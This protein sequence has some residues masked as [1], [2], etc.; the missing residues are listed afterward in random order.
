M[1][2]ALCDVPSGMP[3]V[4]NVVSY[5]FADMEKAAARN[6]EVQAARVRKEKVLGKTHMKAV[7]KNMNITV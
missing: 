5:I 1:C 6:C 4:L 2:E 3:S 7:T